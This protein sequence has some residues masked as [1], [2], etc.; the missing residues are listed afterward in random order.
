MSETHQTLRL[1]FP[2]WQGG[3]NPAYHFGARLL[4][5]LA[6]QA[7]GEVEEIA[8]ANP[9]DANLTDENG[10][11]GRTVLLQQLNA[12]QAAINK[13]R[14]ARIVTLGG[15][16]LIDLAPFAYL[17]ELYGQDLGILWLD[18]HP[19][20]MTPEQFNHA[21]AMVLGNL[22]GC[23]DDDFRSAVTV[24]V[25]A[26]N[27]LLAGLGETLPAESDFIRQHG[28]KTLG[29]EALNQSSKPVLRWI[30]DNNIK[31]LAIHLDLDVIDVNDFRSL[32]F[33]NTDVA[34]GT[35]DGI[36]QGKMTMAAVQRLLCDVGENVDVVGLGIAE[37]LPWDSL[38]LSNMLAALPLL[39]D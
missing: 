2:Q 36:T 29:P 9:T 16:C 1:H 38:K 24:P 26:D 17:S 27:V 4:A 7:T 6:P 20:V 28:L 13:H 14:P 22:L 12:A 10:I 11:V 35:F 5:F 31:K 8:V 18:A 25:S 37:H 30:K 34:P 3:N 33:A 39:R 32:L 21:H 23:G 19:D 15:D